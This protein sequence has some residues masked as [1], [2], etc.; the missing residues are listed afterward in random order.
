MVCLDSRDKKVTQPVGQNNHAT[1]RDKKSTLSIG[2]IASKLG[3][4]SSE[5]N[6]LT[7]DFF[8]KGSDPPPLI[9]GS[10]GTDREHWR[11]CCLHNFFFFFTFP[12]HFC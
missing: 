7:M 10:S 8:R 2:P 6:G 3:K 4:P 1:S 11:K 9:L 5:K 12:E